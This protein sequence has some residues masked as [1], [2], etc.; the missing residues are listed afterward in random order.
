MKYRENR[1]LP[2]KQLLLR[3]NRVVQGLPKH[4]RQNKDLAVVLCPQSPVP[5]VRK[6]DCLFFPWNL[7]GLEDERFPVDVCT[8]IPVFA[9]VSSTHPLC[10][11]A[12]QAVN[13]TQLPEHEAQE[14][15]QLT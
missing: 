13:L 15:S 3:Y 8:Q 12:V 7:F 6:P 11:S 14:K 2:Y 10:L 1:S 4:G 5:M 9:A